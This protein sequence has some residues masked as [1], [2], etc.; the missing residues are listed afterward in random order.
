MDALCQNCDRHPGGGWP[1]ARPQYHASRCIS[2]SEYCMTDSSRVPSTCAQKAI[3]S[4]LIIHSIPSRLIYVAVDNPSLFLS[5]SCLITGSYLWNYLR[6]AD[7][8]SMLKTCKVMAAGA[9]LTCTKFDTGSKLPEFS[10][11]VV[12]ARANQYSTKAP[13]SFWRLICI[14]I[15]V[16]TG[17]AHSARHDTSPGV[18]SPTPSHSVDPICA[19]FGFLC[20]G[21]SE[22]CIHLLNSQLEA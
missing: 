3:L 12:S 6:A 2:P 10:G 18:A 21:T 8:G 14:V 11:I 9:V 19:S 13:S 16:A 20:I 4:L 5:I 1:H 7:D 22:I 17:D 15:A